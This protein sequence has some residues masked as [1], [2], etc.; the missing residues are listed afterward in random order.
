[1]AFD[2]A[3]IF[4]VSHL[5]TFLGGT[6]V[7]AAASYMADR[8][9]DRRRKSEVASEAKQRFSKIR[10]LLPDLAAELK[11]DLSQPDNRLV[12]EFVVLSNERVSF[13]HDRPR[14]EYYESNHPEIQNQVRLLVDAGYVR[15]VSTTNYPVYRMSDEFVDYLNET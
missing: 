13:N 1:M 15:N 8:F 3:S 12:R 5:A 7:G 2:P 6:A 11:T 10:D 14:F 9:T 4:D